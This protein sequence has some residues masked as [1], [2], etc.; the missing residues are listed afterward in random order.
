MYGTRPRS[1]RVAKDLECVRQRILTQIPM[2]RGELRRAEHA[3]LQRDTAEV[4]HALRTA[5]YEL[6]HAEV[7]LEALPALIDQEPAASE[8]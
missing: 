6:Q 5:K 1:D 7:A 4:R 2:L 3:L 8:L